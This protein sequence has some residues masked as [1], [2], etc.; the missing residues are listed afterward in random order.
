M[1][2]EYSLILALSGMAFNA[3]STLSSVINIYLLETE[4][5]ICTYRT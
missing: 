5:S 2:F 1:S 4:I 3:D